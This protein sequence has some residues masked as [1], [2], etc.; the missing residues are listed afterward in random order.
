MGR[1]RIR[2]PAAQS[3]LRD[4]LRLFPKGWNPGSGATTPRPSACTMPG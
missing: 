1:R 3:S 4:R 2:P